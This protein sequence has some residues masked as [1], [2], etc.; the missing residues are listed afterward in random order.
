MLINRTC[1]TRLGEFSLHAYLINVLCACL[2]LLVLLSLFAPGSAQA[3]PPFKPDPSLPVS[4]VPP[5]VQQLRRDMLDP[6]INVLTFRSMDRIFTTR[7]VARSGSVW[8][9][10]RA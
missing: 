10:P 8:Q 9:L 5:A 3:Y 4:T 7:T 6:G 1:G 2:T